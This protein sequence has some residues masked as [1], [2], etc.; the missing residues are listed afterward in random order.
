MVM[1]TSSQQQVAEIE[2]WIDAATAA[3][4]VLGWLTPDEAERIGA[5]ID[6]TASQIAALSPSAGADRR[7]D[8]DRAD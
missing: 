2:K 3:L 4:S 7:D 8:L 1:S 6:R 5:P